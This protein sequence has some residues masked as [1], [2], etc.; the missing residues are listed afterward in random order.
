MRI[1]V[2]HTCGTANSTTALIPAYFFDYSHS[3]E[4]VNDTA[5]LCGR[6]FM[7]RKLLFDFNYL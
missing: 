4:L 2:I 7:F 5:V 6:Y 3:L 1:E